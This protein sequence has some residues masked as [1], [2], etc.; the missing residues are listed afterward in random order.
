MEMEIPGVDTDKGLELCDG[1]LAMYLRFL[2]LYAT[3]V[4]GSLEKMRNVSEEKLHDY[5][6]TAHSVKSNNEVIGAEESTK[7]ARQLEAMAK[8]GDLAGVLALNDAFIK[9]SESLVGCIQSW[10]KKTDAN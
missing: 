10:L 9:D 1:D 8:A 3:N 2:R 6:L 5:I 4:P 7:R